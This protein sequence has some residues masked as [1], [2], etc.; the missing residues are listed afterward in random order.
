MGS[1]H[2]RL[3]HRGPLPRTE[4]PY[5]FHR[6]MATE[7]G[8][9]KTDGRRILNEEAAVPD[10]PLW[11]VDNMAY[12]KAKAKANPSQWAWFDKKPSERKLE[13]AIPE[14]EPEEDG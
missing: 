6:G 3:L 7:V 2:E 8:A 5:S 14:P 13:D 11:A 9:L 10:G 12:F 4:G 1:A